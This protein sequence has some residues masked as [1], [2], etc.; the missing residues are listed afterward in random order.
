LMVAPKFGPPTSTQV[1][2]RHSPDTP[3]CTAGSLSVPADT[4]SPFV[5][6]GERGSSLGVILAGSEPV[7]THG[8]RIVL[9]DPDSVKIAPS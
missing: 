8:V 7:P 1:L 5:A 6:K 4:E 2:L 9:A 3:S